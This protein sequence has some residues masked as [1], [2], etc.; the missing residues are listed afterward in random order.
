MGK[1]GMS[2]GRGSKGS[3]ST[4]QTKTS[5]GRG[6]KGSLSSLLVGRNRSKGV[7]PAQLKRPWKQDA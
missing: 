2:T 4:L 3:L 6:S 1:Y 7:L 5:R